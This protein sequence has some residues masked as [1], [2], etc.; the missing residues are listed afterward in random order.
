MKRYEFRQGDI[1]HFPY[2]TMQNGFYYA[3]PYWIYSK[4]EMEGVG[5]PIKMDGLQWITPEEEEELE[6]NCL[7]CMGL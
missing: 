4:I 1:L 6:S 3:G 5:K 2:T 7:I